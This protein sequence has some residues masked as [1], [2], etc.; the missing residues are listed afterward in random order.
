MSEYRRFS[1]RFDEDVYEITPET[2]IA[3]RDVPGG[4]APRRVEAA[5]AEAKRLLEA[6]LA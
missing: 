6:P 2:S 1:P 3:D 4:V 5:L